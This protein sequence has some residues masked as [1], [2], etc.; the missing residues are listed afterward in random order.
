MGEHNALERK[1]PFYQ[2]KCEVLATQTKKRISFP[3]AEEEVKERF[4]QDGKQFRFVS[5]VS[6]VRGDVK[7]EKSPRI[8]LG[9]RMWKCREI[10]TDPNR[11]PLSSKLPGKGNL[12]HRTQ[13]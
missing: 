13:R 11:I 5:Y 3:E 4:R 12:K 2:F 7:I 8:Q 10:L 1:R 9:D 6:R